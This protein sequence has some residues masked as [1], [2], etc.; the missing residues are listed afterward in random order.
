MTKAMKRVQF[1][2]AAKT[3]TIPLEVAEHPLFSHF[4]EAIEQAMYGKGTR[5]GGATTPFLQ[6]PWVHYAKMSGRGFLTGQAAKK[7]EEAA[8][9]RVGDSFMLEMYGAMVYSGMAVIHE[10]AAMQAKPADTAK[11]A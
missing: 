9:Q 1:N 4:M 3:A 6:Q 11:G 2:A 7:L 5:H 8:S 10:T